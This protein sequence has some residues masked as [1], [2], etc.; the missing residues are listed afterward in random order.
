MGGE[1]GGKRRKGLENVTYDD[2]APN[3]NAGGVCKSPI[4]ET[5]LSRFF[6]AAK[7]DDCGSSMSRPYRHLYR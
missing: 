1:E 2:R 7:A 5:E 6:N 3:D 4:A